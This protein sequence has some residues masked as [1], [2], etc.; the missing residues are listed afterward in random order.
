VSK[1][2]V[3]KKDG[4]LTKK[5]RDLPRYPVIFKYEDD[6]KD[7]FKSIMYVALVDFKKELKTKLRSNR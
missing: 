1:D 7:S 3:K 6:F 2:K 5:Y 4:T